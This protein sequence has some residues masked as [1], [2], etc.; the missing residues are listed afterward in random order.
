MEQA[1]TS[2]YISEYSIMSKE[3]FKEL[4]LMGKLKT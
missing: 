1:T 4:I 3:A 2:E